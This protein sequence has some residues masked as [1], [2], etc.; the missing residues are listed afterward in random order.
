IVI[1]WGIPNGDEYPNF[2]FTY[3]P[4]AGQGAFGTDSFTYRVS[5]GWHVSRYATQVDI[6]Q[7]LEPL[8]HAPAPSVVVRVAEGADFPYYRPNAPFTGAQLLAAATFSTGL[9]VSP[10]LLAGAEFL[11]RTPEG[12]RMKD[13]YLHD[14]PTDGTYQLIPIDQNVHAPDDYV[15]DGPEDA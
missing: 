3:L 5:D 11:L 9:P 10:Y 1:K 4:F 14:F 8:E 12:Q 2:Y 6:R 15:A 13:D 7:T